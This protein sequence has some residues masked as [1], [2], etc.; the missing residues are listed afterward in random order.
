[1]RG[2][3]LLLVRGGIQWRDTFYPLAELKANRI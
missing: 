3:V 2:I 1:V